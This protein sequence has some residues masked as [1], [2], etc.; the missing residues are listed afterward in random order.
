M[1]LLTHQKK[2]NGC[3]ATIE[4]GLHLKFDPEEFYC[5]DPC[6]H[7]NYSEENLDEFFEAGLLTWEVFE[8][9]EREQ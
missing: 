2:C 3:G 5:D 9:M 7:V 6:T 4:S 1:K 8:E